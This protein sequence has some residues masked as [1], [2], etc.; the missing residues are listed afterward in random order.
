MKSEETIGQRDERRH[1]EMMAATIAGGMAAFGSDDGGGSWPL[2]QIPERAVML[3]SQVCAAV[4]GQRERA[5][6]VAAAKIG[7]P[8]PL[9]TAV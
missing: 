5:A 7:A 6:I 4:Q 2:A 3:A 9:G 8:P 1:I